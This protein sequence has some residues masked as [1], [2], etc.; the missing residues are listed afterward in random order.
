MTK[1]FPYLP[2][3]LLNKVLKYNDAINEYSHPPVLPATLLAINQEIYTTK[4]NTH[5]ITQN[6]SPLN[7]ALSNLQELIS[8]AP[9]NPAIITIQETKLTATKSTKFIQKL[10]PKYKLIFNNTHALT[11]CIQ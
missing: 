8:N 3:N 9:N 4:Y 11:R 5:I 6:A 10:F 2:E 1:E 7:T